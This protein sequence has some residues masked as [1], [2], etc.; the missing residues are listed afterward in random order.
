MMLTTGSYV[1]LVAEHGEL[2]GRR[3]AGLGRAAEQR[4]DAS[5]VRPPP[6]CSLQQVR[7]AWRARL[8]QARSTTSVLDHP[9]RRRGRA[10]GRVPRPAR[11][12]TRP[13]PSAR[14]PAVRRAC[15]R[16]ALPQ[17][18]TPLAVPAR[19]GLTA[20]ARGPWACQAVAAPARQPPGGAALVA[21]PG[22][23]LIVLVAARCSADAA[24]SSVDSDSEVAAPESG[25]G[26]DGEEDASS[27]SCQ[28]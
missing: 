5:G 17:A 6:V 12:V 18:T 3:A 14:P 7:V 26:T 22:C 27:V 25:G 15:L 23:C 21:A 2:E 10:S 24:R 8:Q 19:R 4:P 11:V 9:W 13:T 16:R 28:H 20:P 1:R